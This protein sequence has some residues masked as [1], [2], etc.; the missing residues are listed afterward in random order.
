MLSRQRR[1]AGT[2]TV[3][4]RWASWGVIDVHGIQSA[5]MAMTARE[6]IMRQGRPTSGT[7]LLLL[8]NWICIQATPGLVAPRGASAA[9]RSPVVCCPDPMRDQ[10]ADSGSVQRW[11]QSADAPLKWATTT[12]TAVPSKNNR[13]V[14]ERRHRA[15]NFVFIATSIGWL[16]RR[17]ANARM[18][19]NQTDRDTGAEGRE[20]GADM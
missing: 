17:K 9:R 7:S 19:R 2:G 15:D 16:R 10:S 14:A 1:R 5:G 8:A 11:Q 4:C 12:T 18:R 20:S 6:V 3:P 13:P